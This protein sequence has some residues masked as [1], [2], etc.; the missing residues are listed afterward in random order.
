[1]SIR[2]LAALIALGLLHIQPQLI[3]HGKHTLFRRYIAKISDVRG[4]LQI[5]LAYL[6]PLVLCTT[7]MALLHRFPLAELLHFIFAV[8][9]LLFCLGSHTYE[10]VLKTILRASDSASREEAAQ[11]LGESDQ[12]VH[13][14]P[15]G[16]IENMIQAALHRRFGILL[17][18]FLLGPLGALLY[19]LT[20]LLG[21]DQSLHL[22]SN[23]HMTALKI[24]NILDWL[25]AQLL[26]LA[27]ALVGH[28]AVVV[29]TWRSWHQRAQADDWYQRGPGFLT[30][31]AYAE[32]S[33]Y[34]RD[35]HD[36]TS[37]HDETLLSI[38]CLRG[39]LLRALFLWLS[40]IALTIIIN[41][42]Q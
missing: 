22:D 3:Q 6:L 32:V 21:R 27:L 7:L 1:M 4:I 26:V 34:T 33:S 30:S 19:H 15:D 17:Y 8:T 39:S 28:W 29:A 18:F 16:L 11:D 40:V 12:Y 38:R 36:T 37:H 41:W 31:A 20:G 10:A 24:N 42:L 2:L 14:N 5:G 25:P 23:A 13:W 35:Y 9:V